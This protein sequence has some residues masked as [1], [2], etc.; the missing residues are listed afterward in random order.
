MANKACNEVVPVANMPMTVFDMISAMQNKYADRVAFRYVEGKD[1]VVEK[2]YAQYVQDIRKA[3][4]YLQQELGEPKGK[5]SVILS[6]TNYEYGAVVFGT[7]MAGAVIVT[8]N[9]GKTW[10]E[11]E[12]EL[13]L[14]EPALILNDGIDYGCRAELEAA[15]GPKLRPM[16][17]YKD[18]A[19]GELTNCVGHD[20][21]MMLMFTSGTTGR[22]KAVMLSERNF[23][24][25]VE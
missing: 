23:F 15:Y 9:Q 11:L 17:C 1:T 5:K 22:S 25:T 14:V 24:T 18:T 2:T 19:P 12:Y 20:D 21:L 4:G 8:L 16:D 3:T 13:G 6:R 10:A 7:M